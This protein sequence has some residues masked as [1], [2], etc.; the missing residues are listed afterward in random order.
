MRKNPDP[1]MSR[2][3]KCGGLFPKYRHC[4]PCTTRGERAIRASASF[5]AEEIDAF[6]EI[7]R[8]LRLNGDLSQL[9]RSPALHRFEAKFLRMRDRIRDAK[10]KKGG[11]T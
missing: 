2:C 9:R 5:R 1:P 7:C 3:K 11:A 4:P 6:V 8:A 10:A